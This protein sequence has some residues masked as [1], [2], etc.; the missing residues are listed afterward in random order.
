MRTLARQRSPLNRTLAVPAWRRRAAPLRLL[1]ICLLLVLGRPLAS[2]PAAELS[3]YDLK[4]LYLYNFTQFVT[5]PD[6][7]K[8]DSSRPILIGIMGDDPFG[9]RLENLAT[10]G[11]GERP[12]IE[13]KRLSSPAE[14]RQCDIL[15]IGKSAKRSLGPVLAAVAQAPVLTVGDDD[16]Y[17]LRGCIVGFYLERGTVRFSINER[18]AEDSGLTL[19]SKLLRVAKPR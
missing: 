14:A 2:L 17:A 9:G 11:G 13:V 3:E 6:R 7:E 10:S 16:S 15:F 5:W 8:G 18:A 1:G 4:A 12:A 19:S